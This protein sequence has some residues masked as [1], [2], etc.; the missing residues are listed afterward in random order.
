MTKR[1]YTY[2]ETHAASLEHFHG[3]GL[4]ADVFTGKY[5]LQD[6]KGVLY[7]KSPD[8]MHNRLAREFHRIECNYENPTSLE[9][10][11]G[12]LSSWEV[13]P[14]GGPMSAIGNPYQ[15]QSMSNCFVIGS[16]YDSYGGIMRTDHEAPRWRWI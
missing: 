10:I 2:D 3:D 9:V 5:A 14:Q 6:L 7:E 15:I 1:T 4:A 13:V 8:D 12:L 11:K 16:P